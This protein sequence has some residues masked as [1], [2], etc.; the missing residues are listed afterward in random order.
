MKT[1]IANDDFYSNAPPK[2]KKYL[3]RY[4]DDGFTEWRIRVETGD[5]EYASMVHR[6]DGPAVLWDDGYEEWC[7]KSR[8]HRTDGPAIIDPIENI[9]DWYIDGV[10]IHNY[11]RLQIL[12]KC[13]DEHIIFLKLKWGEMK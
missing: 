2:D 3:V 11:E 8:Y 10:R 4:P 6:E 5:D 9:Q 7:V 13:S 12:T 1:Y